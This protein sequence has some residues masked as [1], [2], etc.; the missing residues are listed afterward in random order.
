M[1]ASM[2]HDAPAAHPVRE[3][4]GLDRIRGRSRDELADAVEFLAWYAPGIFTAA[5]DYMDT[6]DGEPIPG[7]G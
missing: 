6:I 3:V 7:R 4:A 2:T 5:F 1:N